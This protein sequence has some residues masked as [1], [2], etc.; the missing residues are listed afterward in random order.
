MP[1]TVNTRD[2]ITIEN[3]PDDVPPDAP[4][5]KERVAKIRSQR[6][7]HQTQVSAPKSGYLLGLRDP[8][9]ALAQMAENAVPAGVATKVNQFNNWL[10]DRGFPLTRVEESA[11]G[12][13]KLVQAVNEQYQKQRK[14]EA[15][16]VSSLVTGQPADPGFDLG[17]AAGNV[18]NPVTIMATPAFTGA[19]TALQLARAGAVSGAIGGV[20]QPQ[21]EDLDNFWSNKAA[22]AATGAATGAVVTPAVAKVT[23]AGV[24]GATAAR[25]RLTS[26]PPINVDVAVNNIIRQQGVNPAEVTDEMLAGVRRQVED[27]ART[28]QP[29]DAAAMVRRARFEALGLTGESGPTVGQVTRDPIQYAQER[30]LSGV[31]L[32]TPQG[33]G[34]P[35]ATRLQNQTNQLG[36]VFTG[37]GANQATDR[38]TAGQT[39]MDALRQADA[40]V[41]A[42]VDDAYGTARSMNSGRAAPLERGTFS[43]NANQALE[44]GQ[45]GR[46]LP[47]QVRELLNDI[48][49]GQTPFDV[50][51][52]V[53]IDSILSAVQRKAGQGSP[54]ASAVGVVRNALRDTPL[55][56]TDLPDGGA[57]QAAREAFDAAR[58]LARDRFS[59]I[60]RTPALSAALDDV[61]PDQFVQRYV[62]GA[63]VRDVQAMREVLQNNPEALAQLRAQVANHLRR[64]A[65]GENLAG[66]APFAPVRYAEAIRALGPQRLAV[67]FTPQEVGQLNLAAQVASDINSVPAGAKNAV[68]YSGT[69]A[70]V[71]NLLG[72]LSESSFLRGIPGARSLANSVGEIRTEAQIN[73]ALSG[74]PPVQAPQPSPEAL[75]ALSRLFPLAGTAAGG[76]S[77]VQSQ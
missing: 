6:Q 24:R 14:A 34:N 18:L 74:Q 57:G 72:K 68:N 5:L 1:Y 22:Q 10:V 58:G 75:R 47:P 46:F 67:F 21:T 76:L 60:E 27:A 29:M 52:A 63:P 70:A 42:A 16:G 56:M 44:Q 71:M 11:Q 61:A 55:S 7:P 73:Q 26:R 43:Q 51:A 36:E 41:R 31:V 2:G 19:R 13:S 25:N 38:L 17:R 45:W 64:A 35:L 40:P 20:L 12:T 59:T 48:S 33:Q 3:V 15:G 65:F 23:Q 50:D 4:A 62:L 53:Q 32:N 30:N 9:D 37:V 54:E 69:G 66:D 39:L 28:G 77:G 8:V 49:S